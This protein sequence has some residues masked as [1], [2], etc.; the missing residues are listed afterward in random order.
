MIRGLAEELAARKYSHVER[1]RRFLVDVGRCPELSD[2]AAIR[3][4]DRYISGTRFR[5]RRMTDLASGRIVLK[6]SKKYD[7]P[8]VLARPMV[9]AYLT[10]AEY[11]LFAA[12][13]ARPL[14]KTRYAVT[15]ISGTFGI[16][17]FAGALTGLV[18]AEIECADEPAIRKVQA[19]GWAVREVTHDERFQ[20][21]ALAN[22]APQALAPLLA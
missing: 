3:I 15:E 12:M 17:V 20:G 9:T 4:E 7:V 5:L 18:L 6:L 22:I 13:V 21:A 8:D 16:D 19:P 10:E 1:E 14:T 2:A 11:D